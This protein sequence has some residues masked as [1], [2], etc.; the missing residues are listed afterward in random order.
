MS[1]ALESEEE[2]KRDNFLI[3]KRVFMQIS[4]KKQK[5]RLFEKKERKIKKQQN[6]CGRHSSKQD[7]C[8]ILARER[9]NEPR[10]KQHYYVIL[11]AN[12]NLLGTT[13]TA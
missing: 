5:E 10:V 6:S 9:A 2:W 8:S 13:D 4:L 3:S 7:L 12:I 1:V 11:W